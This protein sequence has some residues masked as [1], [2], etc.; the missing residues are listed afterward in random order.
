[1]VGDTPWDKGAPAPSLQEVFASGH[2]PNDAEVLVPGCGFGHDVLAWS[3]AGWAATG[4]DISSTAIRGAQFLSQENPQIN[5]LLADLF[6]SELPKQKRYGII[7][8]HTCYC[9]ILPE[10]RKQYAQ[11]AANLL[12][13][14]G[15]FAGVFF[16]NT[17]MPLGEGPPFETSISEV[18]EVFAPYFN[19]LWHK[20]PELA[21]P[22]R[23]QKEWLA[24]LKKRT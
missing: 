10:Q 16:T 24:I 7:W 22:G 1:M 14:G 21:Y 18:R 23:E 20:V 13:D 9:A 17:E 3:D 19:I 6:D 15:I 11:C 2:I 4:L 8:E 5:F 12:N